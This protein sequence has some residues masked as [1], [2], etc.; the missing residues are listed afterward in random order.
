MLEMVLNGLDYKLRSVVWRELR[1]LACPA[2]WVF[3]LSLLVEFKR[4]LPI[5]ELQKGLQIYKS[6]RRSCTKIDKHK[7]LVFIFF[8][9]VRVN[10]IINYINPFKEY[11]IQ[12]SS[13]WIKR[14]ITINFIISQ[15]KVRFC[16]LLCKGRIALCICEYFVHFLLI[17]FS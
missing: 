1:D 11:I 16:H 5:M 15:T 14:N 4:L 2:H 17:F 3:T 12:K 9:Q 13:S 6:N 8:L 7:L 10:V